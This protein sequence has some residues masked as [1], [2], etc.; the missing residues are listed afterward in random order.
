MRCFANTIR[1]PALFLLLASV[2]P[3]R[4][5]LPSQAAADV[6]NS[7]R[8]PAG[9]TLLTHE[10]VEHLLPATVYYHGQSAPVQMRNAA[11]AR[12][13]ADGYVL[14][15]VVD[16]SGYA[17][18]VQ[19][20]YQ[21]YLITENVL[22]VGGQ[23]LAPGAYGAGLVRDELIVTD[24]GGHTLLRVPASRD[25][26]MTRPRPLQMLSDSAGGLKLYLG[27]D[28]VSISASVMP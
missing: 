6:Q 19:E 13:G 9:P 5:E 22:L 8:S 25:G 7:S 2:V 14:A 20:T 11:G 12:F 15:A 17:S 23:R 1:I 4:A 18:S 27:R 24:L 3:L 28:W 21:M 16:T 10:Q 26:A